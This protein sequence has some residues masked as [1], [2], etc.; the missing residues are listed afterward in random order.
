[1]AFL[2]PVTTPDAAR[3][4]IVGCRLYA[5]VSHMEVS[6]AADCISVASIFSFH[7]ACR[8]FASDV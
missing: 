4:S 6:V 3:P 1:M 8:N 2:P 5:E 7:E